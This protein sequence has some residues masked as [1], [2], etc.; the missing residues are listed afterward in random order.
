VLETNDDPAATIVTAESDEEIAFQDRSH[1][2]AAR[3]YL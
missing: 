3:P 2:P 1:V